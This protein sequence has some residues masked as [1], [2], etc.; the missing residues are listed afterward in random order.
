MD[1]AAT[2]KDA[3]HA[4]AS[5]NES[6]SKPNSDIPTPETD[7]APDSQL[8]QSHIVPPSHI[9]PT[10]RYIHLPPPTAAE[11]SAFFERAAASH[12]LISTTSSVA[13]KRKAKT[14]ESKP[15]VHPLAVASARLRGRGIDE[16]SKAINLGGLVSG[17]EYFGLTNV[18][19]PPTPKK[20]QEG[21]EDEE[22]EEKAAVEGEATLLDRRL[23]SVYVLKKYRGQYDDASDVLRRKSKRLKASLSGQRVLDARL[24]KLRQ[25]W[26]LSAPERKPGGM[27]R[28]RD[29][30]AVDVEVYDGKNGGAGETEEGQT[31]GRIARKVPRFATMELVEGYDVSS[32]VEL[33]KEKVQSVWKELKGGEKVR[34]DTNR[35]ISEKPTAMEVDGDT[36]LQECKTKAEPFATADSA[37]GHIDPDFDPDK[38][39]LL[40]LLFE[41][42]KPSTGFVQRATLSSSLSDDNHEIPPDERV[43]ESLQHSLF[44]ASLFESMRAEIIP[45]PTYS[46][47]HTQQRNESVA[48]L[49]SEMEESFLPPPSLMAGRDNLHMGEARLLCVVHC[50]EGEVKVQLNDEY[51]LTA[52]LI[53][54][55]TSI[56]AAKDDKPFNQSVG[57]ASIDCNSGSESPERLQTICRALLLHSQSLYHEHRMK[58]IGD[59]KNDEDEATKQVGFARVKKEVK[60]PSPHI[61]Q[62][63]VGLGCR[64]IFERKVRAV[65]KVSFDVHLSHP[66]AL[67]LVQ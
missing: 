53:E 57:E 26:R 65:L 62:S 41:I 15:F 67:C 47:T 33:L 10:G 61:L 8:L 13:A 48:W 9:L 49:S 40:T 46:A 45:P 4:N 38:V 59:K 2:D 29:V 17:G 18:V 25:R 54:V 30:V 16:L 3:N 35:V 19:N 42:E 31:L 36:P 21:G 14:K 24:R 34:D 5:G 63:C 60:R 43:I 50:H 1:E 51:C 55:G 32:D 7:N 28:A 20:S 23:R 39:P 12:R 11:S 58:T 44:C 66:S 52:K 56:G 64:F 27:V 37:K 6:K 22:K